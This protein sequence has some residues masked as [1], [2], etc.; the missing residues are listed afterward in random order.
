MMKIRTKL[1]ALL[2]CFAIQPSGLVQAQQTDEGM[3]EF[4]PSILA[5]IKESAF[6][7]PKE[8]SVKCKKPVAE[9]IDCGT[10]GAGYVE[11]YYVVFLDEDVLPTGI[12]MEVLISTLS[13]PRRFT[14]I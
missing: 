7:N 6:R 10:G 11:N 3:L 13:P 5:G 9:L 1:I 2:L 12:T 8:G 4:I 14:G